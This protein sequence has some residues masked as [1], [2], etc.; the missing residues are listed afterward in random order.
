MSLRRKP[1]TGCPFALERYR[2]A[3]RS[4]RRSDGGS[5]AG[6]E[7]PKLGVVVHPVETERL[8]GILLVDQLT[9]SPSTARS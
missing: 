4:G 3:R 1:A 6:H 5:R 2:G 9:A 7:G 8:G